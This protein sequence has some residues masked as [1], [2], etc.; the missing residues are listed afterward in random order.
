MKRIHLSKLKSGKKDDK[1]QVTDNAA[2]FCAKYDDD[3]KK[4]TFAES[5]EDGIEG[6]AKYGEKKES[7]TENARNLFGA[8]LADTILQDEDKR[9]G[10]I[11]WKKPGGDIRSF[12]FIPEEEQDY[13]LAD[14]SPDDDTKKQVSDHGTCV[15]FFWKRKRKAIPN[16]E[17]L[18]EKIETWYEL[19]NILNPKRKNKVKIEIV[20][21]DKDGKTTSINDLKHAYYQVEKK[22]LIKDIENETVNFERDSFKIIKANMKTVQTE[23]ELEIGSNREERTAGLYIEDENGNVFDLTLFGQS[24]KAYSRLVIGTVVV[25]SDFKRIVQQEMDN[26]EYPL[27]V[28]RTGFDSQHPLTRKLRRTLRKWIEE[29][30]NK[31]KSESA[32]SATNDMGDANKEIDKL[33]RAISDDI[34]GEGETPESLDQAI[35]FSQR[36]YV[37]LEGLIPKRVR[38]FIDTKKIKP[39]QTIDLELASN[40]GQALSGGVVGVNAAGSVFFLD[41]NSFKVPDPDPDSDIVFY[42]IEV[43]CGGVADPADTDTLTAKWQ[44]HTEKDDA[45]LKCIAKSVPPELTGECLF[46]EQ[47]TSN[48]K[49]KFIKEDTL[50]TITLFAY[51]N[52]VDKIDSV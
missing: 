33:M 5:A 42:D 8:G 43:T 19:K 46:W 12:T 37:V 35:Q 24:G 3:T 41:N 50:G 29:G 20:Y 40:A 31:L 25:N 48:R 14:Q 7:H 30:L 27:K 36:N 6:F 39:H 51:S 21:H 10:R 26:G 9:E 22:D 45:N 16:A 32:S 49:T 11:T 34:G 38:V 52:I 1:V 13:L 18:K 28:D 23:H 2:G 15:T 44:N 17:D 4:F 47:N